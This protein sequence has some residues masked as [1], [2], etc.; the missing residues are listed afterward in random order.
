MKK[1]I[2]RNCF[3]TPI[4]KFHILMLLLNLAQG[5]CLNFD[6]FPKMGLTNLLYIHFLSQRQEGMSSQKNATSLHPTVRPIYN[7]L[8]TAVS[9]PFPITLFMVIAERKGEEREG[10]GRRVG[11]GC[12]IDSPYQ[13]CQWNSSFCVRSVLKLNMLKLYKSL[14]N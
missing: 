3:R 13:G 9:P 4:S 5:L 10:Q 8:R 1:T 14:Y 2:V 12:F 7:I 6:C 11:M